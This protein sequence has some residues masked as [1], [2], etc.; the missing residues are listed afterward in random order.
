MDT[1]GARILAVRL[2]AGVMPGT[3]IEIERAAG[4]VSGVAPGDIGTVVDVTEAGV[5]VDWKTGA[6][7]VIDPA[8]VSYR[9]VK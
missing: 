9:P 7:S 8:A 4:P 5:V 1:A 6:R 3:L 2:R